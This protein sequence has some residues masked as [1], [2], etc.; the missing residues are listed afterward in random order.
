[1]RNLI[2]LCSGIALALCACGASQETLTQTTS[3]APAAEPAATPV[4]IEGE[5][6]PPTAAA[7]APPAGIAP[8]P[9]LDSAPS[10]PELRPTPR[11]NDGEIGEVLDNVDDA[12]I[13][14]GELVME[15]SQDPAVKDL[16]AGVVKEHKKA[17]QDLG[18]LL[19]R[20]NIP[21]RDSDLSRA[22]SER[23][24]DNLERL[25]SLEGTALDQA[26]LDGR[27]AMNRELLVALDQSLV[28]SAANQSI[29]E[30]VTALRPMLATHLQHARVLQYR[31]ARR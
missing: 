5:A 30:F 31:M 3:T 12:E 23:A 27:V 29:E 9:P 28:P 15:R 1:M 20:L 22:L 8:Q 4:V 14:A 18:A 13:A 21:P 25:E 24:A 11:L 6:A 19:L 26:Y 17:N 10:T 2:V 7:P 16:A